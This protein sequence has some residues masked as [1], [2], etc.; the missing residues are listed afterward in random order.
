MIRLKNIKIWK[1]R[2]VTL[3]LIVIMLLSLS[4]CGFIQKDVLYDYEVQT[5]TEGSS[6][7]T[8]AVV[9]KYD[10]LF[11]GNMLAY[12]YW[13]D[14]AI[15]TS[16]TS[17]EGAQNGYGLHFYQTDVQKNVSVSLNRFVNASAS[18]NGEVYFC[19]RD[20]S[21]TE[22]VYKADALLEKKT[23]LAKGEAS[24]S[25]V[26][27]VSEG[28]TFLYIDKFNHI[29]KVVE[30][31]ESLLFEIPAGYTPS[32]IRFCETDGIIM[33]IASQPNAVTNNLY[34]IDLDTGTIAAVDVYVTEMSVVTSADKTAYVKIDSQGQR[35]L[36]VYDHN[37]LMRKYIMSGN[38][39]KLTLSPYGGYVAYSTK[40]SEGGSG[41]V[42]IVNCRDYTNVQ[43]TANTTLSGDIY[44]SASERE[45]IFTQSETSSDPEQ[46]ETVYRTYRL[47]FNY[48]YTEE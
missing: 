31:G 6:G 3:C 13:R 12:N 36:Y 35:Q 5:G 1:Y 22:Y 25:V 11:T 45:L 46:K 42:W 28:N 44:W 47:K 29:V 8:T 18:E 19:E 14:I 40:P 39:E 33:M 2:I 17:P 21:N 9:E 37:T 48:D 16:S 38:F 10:T 7:K 15:Y 24:K 34:R 23:L 26:W 30:S 41:S 20:A 27:C 43:V 32:K 4:S